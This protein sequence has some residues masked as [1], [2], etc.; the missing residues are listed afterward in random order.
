[1][2]NTRQNT[3]KTDSTFTI[4]FVLFLFVGC[5]LQYVATPQPNIND[6]SVGDVNPVLRFAHT[7][8]WFL[9]IEAAQLLWNWAIWERYVD[10]PLPQM[11]RDVCAIAKISLFILDEK[12]HGYY[13]H[14]NSPAPYADANMLEMAHDFNAQTGGIMIAQPIPDDETG[15]DN[16]PLHECFEVYVTKAWRDKYDSIFT[17]VSKKALRNKSRQQAQQQN[18]GGDATSGGRGQGSGIAQRLAGGAPPDQLV[19]ASRKLNRFLRRFINKTERDHKREMRENVAAHRVFRIPPELSDLYTSVI[20]GDTESKFTSVLIHGVE[21]Q[22]MLFNILTWAV[23]DLW[24]DDTVTGMGNNPVAAA[25]VTWLLEKV[26]LWIRA[27]LGSMNI[28]SKT[29]VDGRFLL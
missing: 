16:Q 22:M 7:T 4:F 6:L 9:I 26:Y 28:N 2:E 15:P 20:Y 24:L 18:G 17:S 5:D 11:F 14:C 10:E 8:L 19:K 3:R 1:L 27:T 13:L 29:L 21:M 23:M 12:F 25:L